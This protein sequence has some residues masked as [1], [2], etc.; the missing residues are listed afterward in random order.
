MSELSTPVNANLT[1]S[2][3]YKDEDLLQKVRAELE[4][5]YGKIDMVSP[6]YSFSDISPYY[7]PEMGTDI[8]KQ[9]KR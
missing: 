4:N 6:S 8:K 7:D 1:I 5:S 9:E 2:I 3:M